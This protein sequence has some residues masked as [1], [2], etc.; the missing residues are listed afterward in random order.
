MMCLFPFEPPYF[1]KEGLPA[2]FVGHPLVENDKAHMDPD[3]FRAAH[4]IPQGTTCLGVFL[5][6]RR[7]EIARHGDVFLETIK[8][9]KAAH[10]EICVILPTLPHL[11]ETVSALAAQIGGDVIVTTAQEQKWAAFKACDFALVVSGTVGLELAYVHVP[12][13]MAYKM[14]RLT[15][16]IVRLLIKVKYGHLANILLGREV[17]P[18]CLQENCT[19]DI[20]SR[21]LLSLMEN[22]DER[23][24]QKEA[25]QKVEEMLH[26]SG[27]ATPSDK[28]SLFVKEAFS[29]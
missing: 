16:R 1:E 19:P 9:I 29:R 11:A 18:E 2:V 24:L 4:N 15:A 5:G 25:F 17:V 14:N 27:A 7:G 12:H 28:A 10:P 26:P 8:R 6:S 13:V 22:P 23:A 20:L 3:G 21:T